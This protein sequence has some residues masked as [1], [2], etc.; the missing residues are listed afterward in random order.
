[1]SRPAHLRS[2]KHCWNG[3]TPPLKTGAGD[4]NDRAAALRVGRAR[5]FF[6][7]SLLSAQY[8]PSRLS[9]SESSYCTPADR[10]ILSVTMPTRRTPAPFAASITS[11][12][13]TPCSRSANRHCL[14]IDGQVS[15]RVVFVHDRVWRRI[16]IVRS[17]VRGQV[18]I[19]AFLIQWQG[20]QENH[21]QYEQHA[22]PR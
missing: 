7:P 12:P 20:R 21:E 14:M 22:G 18:G 1:M 4:L 16:G 15:F 9:A 3:S 10:F 17:G 8:R 11:T 6:R 5:R 2:S 19:D 13:R